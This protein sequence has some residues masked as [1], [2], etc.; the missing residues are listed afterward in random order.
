[1]GANTSKSRSSW[2][3]SESADASFHPGND[4]SGKHLSVNAAAALG[5]VHTV[6]RRLINDP[7]LVTRTTLYSSQTLAHI[8]AA[9]GRLAVLELLVDFINKGLVYIGAAASGDSRLHGIST[10]TEL[11][12]SVLNSR[13][14][15]GEKPEEFCHAYANATGSIL[16]PVH[17]APEDT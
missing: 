9:K 8:S 17:S 11:I 5:D 15:K 4:K 3:A 1:M 16:L 6:E 10:R 2:H 12:I 14:R 13:N 7:A